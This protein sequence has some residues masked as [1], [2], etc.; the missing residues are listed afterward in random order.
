[1]EIENLQKEYTDLLE[2]ANNLEQ[3]K[4][5]FQAKLRKAGAYT[6]GDCVVTDDKK[7]GAFWDMDIY[8]HFD[9]HTSDPIYRH[10]KGAK[11]IN[12]LDIPKIT[13]FVEEWYTF[14]TLEEKSELV[15]NFISSLRYFP[16]DMDYEMECMEDAVFDESNNTFVFSRKS[17][18]IS[19][20][21]QIT[22]SSD[23][24]NISVIN[25]APEESEC[26]DGSYFE[27]KLTTESEIIKTK[28]TKKESRG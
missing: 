13:S 27:F 20:G 6:K 5:L 1:M 16:F 4:Q 10:Y 18:K 15:R 28:T 17:T 9:G 7:W 25:D 2:K 8:S 26:C 24:I 22:V 21:L 12:Q 14:K 19:Q 23:L 3:E 11:M